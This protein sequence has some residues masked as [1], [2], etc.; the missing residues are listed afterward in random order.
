MTTLVPPSV[1]VEPGAHAASGDV[2][3]LTLH[4]RNLAA[5][6]VDVRVLVIG[7]EPSWVPEPFTVTG[8]AAD[9]TITVT[10][11]LV[12]VPGA[13]PGDYP[14][15][16][17]VESVVGGVAVRTLADAAVRVDGDSELVVS[18]EPVEARGVRSAAVDVVLV[19]ASSTPAEVQLRA[20]GRDGLDVEVPDR[21]LTVAPRETVRVAARVRSPRVRLVGAR[22]R[23][24]YTVTATGRSAPQHVQ[25]SM[26]VRPLVSSGLARFVGV[27]AVLALWVT[28]VVTVLP[29][30]A[31]RF[32]DRS[33]SIE[34]VTVEAGE[35]AAPGEG[36]GE[37][38][39]SGPGSGSDDG[40]GADDGGPGAGAE[41]VRAAGQITGASP[42]GVT[43]SVVPASS[44]WEA[45]DE[46]AGE[47]ESA[48][49]ASFGAQLGAT[50][51]ALH[52]ALG[53]LRLVASLAAVARPAPTAHAGKTLSVAFPL[54]PTDGST[55][56]MSVVSDDKGAWA[57]AGLSPSARYLV[58]VSKPG[59]QTQRV[60]RSGAEL[61]ATPLE[62]EMRAGT[63][64]LTGEVTGPDGAVGGV[65]IT[66]SDGQTT[67]TTRTATSGTVGRWQVD[68]LATPGTYLVTAASDRLG[69]QSRLVSLAPSGVRTV[70][71]RLR[72]GIAAVSGRTI[73]KDVLGGT[74]GIGGL[75]VTASN[76]TVTRSA[77]TATGD[78]LR[79]GTFVLP[80]LPVPATYTVTVSG[81]GY[82]TVTRELRLGPA[83]RTGWDISV[84][85][86][87]GTVT[88]TVRSTEGPGITG[89]GLTLSSE[90]ETFKTMSDSGGRGTF[91]FSGIPA[92][93]Y[94]LTA[95]SFGYTTAFAQVEVRDG[96]QSVSDLR[97]VPVVDDGL[98]STGSITGRVADATHG[99]VITCD[100]VYDGGDCLVHASVDF[101]R[102]DGTPAT[103]ETS[104]LPSEPYV[105][106]ATDPA[107][108]TGLPPGRY[109]VHLSAPGYEPGSVQV[110]VGMGV[111]AE[112]AT[113]ALVPSP[114]L[115]GT[116]IPRVGT[117]PSGTCVVV[118]PV[119]D[120]VVQDPTGGAAN[121]CVTAVDEC[122]SFTSRCVT[123]QSGTY[124][125]ERLRA[126]QYEVRLANL[127]PTYQTPPPMVLALRPGELRRYDVTVE[128]LGIVNLT[129]LQAQEG[130]A[131]AVAGT[132]DVRARNLTG[133]EVFTTTTD[134]GFATF[135]RL[136]PGTWSISVYDPVTDVDL[137][138]TQVGIDLNQEIAAQLVQTNDISTFTF[139]VGW[140]KTDGVLTPIEGATVRVRGVTRYVGTVPSRETREFS[141][142]AN[143]IATVCTVDDDCENGEL[144]L[145]LVDRIVDITVEAAGFQTVVWNSTPVPDVDEAVLR[146]SGVPFSGRITLRPTPGP[147]DVDPYTGITFEVLQAPPGVG[148]VSLSVD[149]ATGAVSFS[150]SAGSGGNRIRPG[151]WRV[152]ADRAGHTSDE[153]TFEVVPGVP[154]GLVEWELQRYGEVAV[155]VQRSGSTEPVAGVHVTLKQGVQELGTRITDATGLVDFGGFVP[156]SYTLTLRAEGYAQVPAQALTLAPGRAASDPVVVDM[157]Q[158]GSISGLTRTKI[159]DTW[160][161][162]LPGATVTAERDVPATTPP[163]TESFD[164]TSGVDGAYR[165][166]GELDVPGLA[167]GTWRVSASA[168]GH[169]DADYSAPVTG[170][171]SVE[172]A[173][174]QQLTNIG[175]DLA[176][177]PSQLTVTVYDGE[178]KVPGLTVVMRWRDGNVDKTKTACVPD[179][180]DAN[181]PCGPLGPGEYRFLGLLPITYNIS[182]SGGSFL[183]INVPHTVE[184]DSIENLPVAL[185][186]P[187]GSVQGTLVQRGSSGGSSPLVGKVVELSPTQVLDPPLPTRTTLTAA[188]GGFQIQ[189]VVA[190][191]YTLEAR[192]PDVPGADP[193]D[194]PTPGA[195]LVSRTVQIASAQSTFI[196]LTVD[197]TLVAATV[198]VTS[199]HGTD[200]TG[201]QVTLEGDLDEGGSGTFGPATLLRS[202]PGS[203][204]FTASFPQLP[205]GDWTPTVTGPAGHFGSH[206]GTQTAVGATNGTITMAVAER[207]VRLRATAPAGLLID[208]PTTLT[209]GSGPSAFTVPRVVQS[210]ASDTVLYVPTL[211][212][213]LSATSPTGWTTSVTP[214]GTV[215]AGSST[216]TFQVAL[217]LNASAV[218][219]ELCT[220]SAPILQDFS[221]W[222]ELSLPAGV[223]R[224]DREIEVSVGSWSTTVETGADGRASFVVPAATV[225][226]SSFTLGASWDGDGLLGSAVEAS[227]NVSISGQVSDFRVSLCTG[228]AT[229]GSAFAC[230]V[231]LSA[232]GSYSVENRAVTV[233]VSRGGTTVRTFNLT[234][235]DD[236][237]ASFTVSAADVGTSNF[238]LAASWTVPGITT[239]RTASRNVAVTGGGGG[240]G[241]GVGG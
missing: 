34:N 226:T 183:S 81:A 187:G 154:P 107:T 86:E 77:T 202:A 72:P 41:Q 190:G 94:V 142:N 148:Q 83:G 128:R 204:V 5:E 78:E 194:P 47:D 43:V 28:G 65:E 129:V 23:H 147:V 166:T 6:P 19:N 149:P 135:T 120:G 16:V 80:D 184:I 31:E 144:P 203:S 175:V 221:C 199:T 38:P 235:D 116:V 152:R 146:P 69:A 197:P 88:G 2:A 89:A 63:G 4:V 40:E 111:A 14:F 45:T 109:T 145:E 97:L 230:A 90:T 220:G 167:P 67:V 223:S 201:A 17:A 196:E 127:D 207:E 54:A 61:A 82:N 170:A 240:G 113:V 118:S 99:G 131:V 92:G 158:L 176:P 108:G 216:A 156:G 102:L 96:K 30:L 126:G 123:L 3:T 85:I 143:G 234:T 219:L 151:T 53:A 73:G 8:V 121:P 139:F 225:G 104:V 212:V 174:G 237:E 217:G 75:T 200:L 76:G 44:L 193:D 70:D 115:T 182:V 130:G 27:L 162:T 52:P 195:V 206:T 15:V 140:Q 205:P 33:T 169:Q 222:A 241:G 112:A 208:V 239:A 56:R 215:A 26:S 68:G 150:D 238:T 163:V 192:E 12:P 209:V 236:G 157:V 228:N 55:Q 98:T 124:T 122:N 125:V 46:E 213:S 191:T 59:F 132:V 137:V 95:E 106:P 188:N 7:L 233:T 42:A 79:A 100:T 110:T 133:T 48:Q 64:Q 60:L 198:N 168:P 119:V 84:G 49:A 25:A 189:D 74:S 178:D 155:K 231:T 114:S 136:V 9:E 29:Q 159:T 37:G 211:G 20:V 186:A 153:A 58:S 229:Q 71:L 134:N 172:L 32:S 87:G 66:I 57:I 62:T 36:S 185:T 51:A 227:R 180:G 160:F 103:L 161:Q 93:T 177:N 179:P 101:E 117:L 13:T 164:A 21:A 35:E 218:D 173:A 10:L 232:P 22:R 171:S 105:L 165:V 141:T 138:S 210:G 11:P 214:S 181:D 91:L 1:L 50:V 24:A 39:G 18:I 224:A